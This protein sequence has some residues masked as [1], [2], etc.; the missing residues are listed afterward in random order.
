[1]DEFDWDQAV[2]LEVVE[3]AVPGPVSER[4]PAATQFD[5]DEHEIASR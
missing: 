2:P 3:I 5:T 1:V 4:S